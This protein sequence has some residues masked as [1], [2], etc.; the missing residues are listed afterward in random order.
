M[1][2]LW[3]YVAIFAV[4]AGA[5]LTGGL[6]FLENELIDARFRLVQRD[7]SGDVLLVT[8]DSRSLREVGVWP[9]PR[10]LHATAIDRLVAAGARDIAY[11]VDFNS[12]SAE[13]ES[14]KWLWVR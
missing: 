1:K 6:D 7:A 11:D 5:S 13:R 2:T 9:W 14:S 3:L 8:I 10:S 12:R 4:V